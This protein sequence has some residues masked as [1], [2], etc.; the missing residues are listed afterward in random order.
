MDNKIFLSKYF[1]YDDFTDKVNQVVYCDKKPNIFYT[2]VYGYQAALYLVGQI[3]FCEISS[4]IDK[5][6]KPIK[7]CCDLLYNITK[8][9]III[10]DDNEDYTGD[11]VLCI[12][13]ADRQRY[14]SLCTYSETYSEPKIEKI[15]DTFIITYSSS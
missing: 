11:D 7:N 6:R 1:L 9:K 5:Y 4:A 3:K 12:F 2:N 14:S 13:F 8:D 15:E 10:S